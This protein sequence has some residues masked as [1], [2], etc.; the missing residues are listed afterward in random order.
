MA[1]PLGQSPPSAADL[2]ARLKACAKNRDLAQGKLLHN[3]ILSSDSHRRDN[4]LANL[5]IAMY[6]RCGS[7]DLAR[8]IFDAMEAPNSHS[9]NAM[10]VAYART[11]YVSQARKI[12]DEM[13]AP[14]KGLLTWNAMI[15][16]YARAAD[17]RHAR[18]IFDQMTCRDVVTWNSLLAAYAHAGQLS[19]ARRVFESIPQPDKISW[20]SIVTAYAQNRDIVQA[21]SFYDRVPH[22]TAIAS[23][24]LIKAYGHEG[25]I[26][27]AENIYKNHLKQDLVCSNAMLLAY[28]NNGHLYMAINLFKEMAE[29][30]EITWN[31]MLNAYICSKNLYEARICFDEM[32]QRD[33]VAWTSM[34]TACVNLGNLDEA[35]ALFDSMPNKDATSWTVILT[36]YARSGDILKAHSLF[37]SMPVKDTVA[38]NAMLSAFV[39]AGEMD[40][41]KKLFDKMPI[42]TIVSWNAMVFGYG[43][44]RQVSKAKQMFDVIPRKTLESWNTMLGVYAQNQGLHQARDLFAGFTYK[45]DVISWTTMIT[46][47][48]NVGDLDGAKSCFHQTP[49]R[50]SVSWNAMISAYTHNRLGKEALDFYK[51]MDIEGIEVDE[52]TLVVVFDACSQIGVLKQSQIAHSH[53]SNH[54]CMGCNTKV[55][56]SLINM[57]INCGSL[58]EAK[59]IFDKLEIRDC[60][61]WNTMITA[62]ANSV[63]YSI[64]AMEL[65][66]QMQLDG[67]KPDNITLLAI[68]SACNHSG[69]PDAGLLYFYSV[70]DFGL[71]PTIDHYSS[72]IDLLGRSGRLQEAGELLESMPFEADIVAWVTLLGACKI[73]RDHG[74]AMQVKDQVMELGPQG[75]APYVL[76]SLQ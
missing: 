3:V 23:A 32:P 44:L 24:V 70:T 60:S 14:H 63:G 58:K 71:D 37:L 64:S 9:W 4:Y 15:G 34:V 73:Q 59:I 75:A 22:P 33:I 40:D 7:I 43:R 47:N 19:L 8:Q 31:T 76:L 53:F 18:E 66:W 21:R 55:A 5:L 46:A 12:F 16:S 61:S 49:C 11:G 56:N 67:I 26:V 72:I 36:A 65:F 10:L 6:A 57:Y 68:L 69:N 51:E 39:N 45:P 2:A 62:Y 42:P 74:R 27:E 48:A 17:P 52:S 13:P 29:K 25:N 35:K 1:I 28:A 50:N 54:K 30:D 20:N 38:W 41:A